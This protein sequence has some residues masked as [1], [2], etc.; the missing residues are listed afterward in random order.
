M[1]LRLFDVTKRY[2]AQLA[3]DR[4]SI[5]V[6]P[7]DIY[8][9]IGHNGAGKTTAMRIALGL[10]RPAS[11]AIQI[12][13]LDAAREPREARA[14]SGGLIESPGFHGHWSG[15]RNLRELARIQGLSRRDAEREAETWI[16][17]VGLAH[18][19]SKPVQA[20]SQGMRQRLGIAQALLGSPHVV[21]LDEPTNGLDPEGIADV[22]ELVRSLNREHGITFLISS[23]QLHEL[24]QLCNRVGVLKNGRVVAEAGT[25]DLFGAGTRY[26]LETRDAAGAA[27]VLAELGIAAAESGGAL[28]FDL[29]ARPA[30]D[31][32]GALVAGGVALSAFAPVPHDLERIYLRFPADGR[33]EAQRADARRGAESAASSEVPVSDLALAPATRLAPR[34]PIRRILGADVR[35]WCSSFAVPLLLLAPTL[36]GALAIARRGAQAGQDA[37][38]VGGNAVFSATDVNGFEAVGIAL[39]AGLPVLVFVALGLCSQSIAAEFARGTLRNSLLRPVTRV[40]LAA[41]K[42]GALALLVLASYALLAASA[43]GLAAASFGFEDVSEL[44]PNGARFTL[45]RAADLWAE[46]RLVLAMP[47][48]PL[49]AYVAIGFVASALVRAGA[50]ALALALGVGVVLDLGRSFTRALGARS[51]LPSDH[52]PSPLSDTSFVRFYVDV[53]QGVSNATFEHGA[54]SVWVPAAWAAVAIVLALALVHRRDVP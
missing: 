41:G 27:R 52:L 35:R 34:D 18:A 42:L 5:G 37:R 43:V 20:Y 2:G 25:A 32:A 9:F 7:G 33:V 17:R 53:A 13:G 39:Q 54:L 23:H 30:A 10:V 16:E 21:L 46:L 50:A 49:L 12:D 8:G 6:R 26:R 19:G 31:V 22:R 36:A 15:T 48:A 47:L 3:L 44:L 40:Q 45:V 1:S 28:E 51:L 11:G 14:R 29:G 24:A 38:D 4:V